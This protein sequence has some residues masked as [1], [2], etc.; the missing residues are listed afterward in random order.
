MRKKELVPLAKLIAEDT[1]FKRA[2]KK[3]FPKL[4]K[5]IEEVIKENPESKASKRLEV[6]L[7]RI[8]LTVH[9]PQFG[10]CIGPLFTEC[11]V[12]EEED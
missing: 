8:R 3:D 7:K 4:V 11:E 6:Q 9:P 2:L 5:L 10:L 12:D 1:R